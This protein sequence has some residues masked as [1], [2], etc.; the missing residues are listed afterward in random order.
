MHRPHCPKLASREINPT[1]PQH[2]SAPTQCHDG[3][4]PGFT[5]VNTP[6]GPASRSK[7]PPPN[8]IVEIPNKTGSQT[9]RLTR[10]NPQRTHRAY[11]N[12]QAITKFGPA[13]INE[14]H[15]AHHECHVVRIS[16]TLY[17][18]RRTHH[19]QHFPTHSVRPGRPT[20][21]SRNSGTTPGR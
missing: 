15:T 17:A 21:Q 1:T 4:T 2:P 16:P 6:P 18:L 13:G 7:H 14:S 19:R 20:K 8:V 12:R 5:L 3:H 11:R 9:L 10:A